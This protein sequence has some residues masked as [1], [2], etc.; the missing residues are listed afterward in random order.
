M[1]LKFF[2]KR[3]L[4]FFSIVLKIKYVNTSSTELTI[5]PLVFNNFNKTSTMCDAKGYS[6]LGDNTLGWANN[7]TENGARGILTM[8]HKEAFK[9]ERNILGK[10]FLLTMGEY[11]KASTHLV[12]INVYSYCNMEEKWGMWKDITNIKWGELYNLGCVV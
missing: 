4:L 11:I 1:E 10:C 5:C 9:C 2:I 7:E 6:I 3:L 12:V 8:W